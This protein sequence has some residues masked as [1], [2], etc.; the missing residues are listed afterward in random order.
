[1]KANKI[2]HYFIFMFLIIFN[3]YFVHAQNID[4]MINIAER[5][6]KLLVNGKGKITYAATFNTESDYYKEVIIDRLEELRANGGSY[7]VVLNTKG[8]MEFAFDK[9]RYSVT[10]RFNKKPFINE[11]KIVYDGEKKISLQYYSNKNGLILPPSGTIENYNRKKGFIH[12]I[13][14]P[15]YYYYVLGEPVAEFLQR[16]DNQL[17]KEEEMNG[18]LCKVFKGTHHSSG[19]NIIV[20]LGPSDMYHRP[21]HIELISSNSNSEID[22]KEA[23][24]FEYTKDNELFI[25]KK[26]LENA[27]FKTKSNKNW[28]LF[29]SKTYLILEESKFNIELPDTLFQMEFPKGIII[30]DKRTEQLIEN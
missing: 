8:E 3:Q 15:R 20:W 4:E 13:A 10:R 25:L 16:G 12:E 26:I 30:F 23:F 19:E 22:N 5:G 6:D 7:D 17:I 27:Y 1:M 28:T 24:D 2:L 11:I 9:N 29:Y 18:V 21:I 14:D